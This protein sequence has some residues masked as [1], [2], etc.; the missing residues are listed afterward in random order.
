[1]AEYVKAQQNETK[2]G[3]VD[4]LQAIWAAIMADVD[5]TAKP[6]QLEAL[7]LKNIKVSNVISRIVL[8]CDANN[9]L[10]YADLRFVD[11][12]L[13]YY[14]QGS[15]LAHQHRAGILLHRNEDH[16][17]LPPDSQGPVQRGLYLRPGHHLLGSKG[18]VCSGQ[19]SLCQGRRTAR[20]G[21]SPQWPSSPR[22]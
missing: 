16:Q 6:E 1:M 18:S 12:T 3:E 22:S 4:L 10:A 2:I 20:Q 21:K 8:R 5:W 17:G 11:G 7:A 9:S 15:S 19:G 13:L 14:R